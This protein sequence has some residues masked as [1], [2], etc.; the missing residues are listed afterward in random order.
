MKIPFIDNPLQPG[1]QQSIPTV[2]HALASQE[3][4]DGEP[5]DQMVAAADYISELEDF[6]AKVEEYLK[7]KSLD[8][9]P[10]RQQLRKELKELL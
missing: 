3:G 5:Y 2:L 8:G 4:C 9:R 10:I 1:V 6:K 7:Y